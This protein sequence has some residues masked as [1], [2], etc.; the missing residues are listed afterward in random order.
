VKSGTVGRL[1]GGTAHDYCPK[2][3]VETGI[4]KG[5]EARIK[6]Q[7]EKRETAGGFGQK[8][9]KAGWSRAWMEAPRGN[10]ALASSLAALALK[11]NNNKPDGPEFMHFAWSDRCRDSVNAGT[12][13]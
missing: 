10:S 5:K 7:N 1:T 2:Q 9:L 6:R 4:R 3:R 11:S 13:V 8:M 12:L